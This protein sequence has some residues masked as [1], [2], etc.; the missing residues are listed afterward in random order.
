MCSVESSPSLL[1]PASSRPIGRPDASTLIQACGPQ[2][3]KSCRVPQHSPG[4]EVAKMPGLRRTCPSPCPGLRGCPSRVSPCPRSIRP[5]RTAPRPFPCRVPCPRR[6]RGA[7]RAGA[8]RR[9][10]AG[11][12][13]A[14]DRGAGRTRAAG[15]SARCERHKAK[16]DGER[17][18]SPPTTRCLALSPLAGRSVRRRMPSIVDTV[19]PNP[20][21]RVLAADA[22]AARPL[23]RTKHSLAHNANAAH[24]GAVGLAGTVN[25]ECARL[26][27]RSPETGAQGA[28]PLPRSLD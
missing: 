7:R 21:K 5:P 9:I 16:C 15:P 25:G 17:E 8:L 22:D 19:L 26:V 2:G 23:K 27:T 1:R 3:K 20:R 11:R 14:R 18:G 24:A 6:G 13:V 28:T 10:R 12:T 4:R